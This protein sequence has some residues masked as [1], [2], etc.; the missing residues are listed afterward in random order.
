MNRDIKSKEILARYTAG[1]RIFRDLD[2]DDGIYDFSHSDLRGAVF[3][4]EHL[5][6]SF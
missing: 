3:S 6:A 4:G 1:E 2:R 5:F